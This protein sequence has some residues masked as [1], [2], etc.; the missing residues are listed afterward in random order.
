M[1]KITPEIIDSFKVAD[2]MVT[3]Y[4]DQMNL[5]YIDASREVASKLARDY[6]YYSLVPAFNAALEFR[7]KNAVRTGSFADRMEAAYFIA[8]VWTGN[9]IEMGRLPSEDVT[10][11]IVA[12][13]NK[14]LDVLSD[15]FRSL[16]FP[17]GDPVEDD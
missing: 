16:R 17:Q 9:Y 10:V 11:F 6:R 12:A 14:R 7:G 4:V 8:E 13:L 15:A 2:S 1:H 5:G 3:L